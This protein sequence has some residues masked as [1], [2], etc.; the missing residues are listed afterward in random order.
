MEIVK[1]YEFES[2]HIVREASSARC[3]YSI[4]GHSYKTE[5][6]IESSR[7][8]DADMVV[9]FIDLKPIKMLVDS[10]DHSHMIGYQDKKFPDYVRSM[11]E[12]S[13]RI[14]ELPLNPTAESIAFI[15]LISAVMLSEDLPGNPFNVSYVRVWETRTG[16]AIARDKDIY[17]LEY[18]DGRKILDVIR[19][20]GFL[21]S[22]KFYD[23]AELPIIIDKINRKVV[24]YE[25]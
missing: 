5:V 9:D 17:T 10:L 23:S 8:N 20:R 18:S 16:S 14:I 2:S 25:N 13:E 11:I 21:I 24:N 1:H 3:K 22:P 4:H 6:A 7:L 15:I 12:N 19:E